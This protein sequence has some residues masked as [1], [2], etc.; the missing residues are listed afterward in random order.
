MTRTVGTA[1]HNGQ[2]LDSASSR[3]AD[4]YRPGVLADLSPARPAPVPVVPA[5]P[6]QTGHLARV[7]ARSSDR[8]G[9]L[10]ARSRGITATDVAK[11]SSPRSIRAAAYDKLHG[12]GFSG[13]VFTEHGR[14]REPEIAA[15]VAATH[16]IQPSD[17]LFH[18]ERDR[19]HLATPDG[20]ILRSSGR[21]ELAEI[22]TT[23]KPLRSI[24]RPYLRQIWWQQYVLGAE[25]TL[26]VWEQHDGFVP[27]GDEPRCRWVDR[28]EAEI[29]K[30]VALAA[31]LIEV[32][33]Q[34]TSTAAPASGPTPVDDRAASPAAATASAAA[35]TGMRVS[36]TA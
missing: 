25:R 16:G 2:V 33:R 31:D 7:V 30:L 3:T 14:S 9:W 12:T 4:L 36:A 27:L 13:N 29:A 35:M 28:D 26:F 22:K 11:L 24:P 10:R 19:R 1:R 32:L 21:I 8:A 15:W 6:G 34:A 18:A 5:V 17:L 23:N 20:L